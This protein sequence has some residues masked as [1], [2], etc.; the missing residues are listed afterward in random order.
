MMKISENILRYLMVHTR[1]KGRL[2]FSSRDALSLILIAGLPFVMVSSL[3]INKSVNQNAAYAYSSAQA[4]TQALPA[5]ADRL[6]R[7]F[8]AL[9]RSNPEALLKMN[10]PHVMA[11]FST[12]GLQRT[13]GD[14]GIWQYRTH[15]CVMDLYIADSGAGVVTHY[16]MRTRVKAGAGSLQDDALDQ[17]TRRDCVK[18]VFNGHDGVTPMIFASR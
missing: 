13:E 15:S 3:S 9:I 5:E 7:H 16:E 10:G 4:P 18:S 1:R 12:P 6:S 2:A 14:M 11:I 8:I 17:A